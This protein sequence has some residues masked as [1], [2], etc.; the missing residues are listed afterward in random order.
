MLTVPCACG[1]SDLGSWE[2]VYEL[3]GGDGRTSSRARPGG[4]RRGNLDPRER[5]ADPRSWG[6][7]TSSSWTRRK[8]SSVMRRGA[9]DALRKSVEKEIAQV[10]TSATAQPAPLGGPARH[11]RAGRPIAG[12]VGRRGR[13]R[14]PS[15]ARAPPHRGR[16]GRGE[17]DA[18]VRARDERSGV[19]RPPCAVHARHAAVRHPRRHGLQPADAGVRVPPGPGL[20]ADPP[21]RRDQ[22]R[23]AEDAGGAPAGD[24]R[25]GRLRRRRDPARSPSRS[26]SSRRRTRSSTSARTR[27]PNRSST[28]S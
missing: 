5:T 2:A 25:A 26:S 15:R 27:S 16:A 6:S 21:G 10:T 24:E 22:P 20:H 18:R 28:G 9:S 19:R 13:G 1:W 4:R 7:R 12:R 14:L 11:D 8:D 17:D 23:D 3:R